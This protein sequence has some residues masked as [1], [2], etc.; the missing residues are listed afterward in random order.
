MTS[1]T[2]ALDRLK[3]SPQRVSV[4]LNAAIHQRLIHRADD[5]GRSLSNLIAFLL[6]TAM[7]RPS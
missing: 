6:E 1:A 4:T 7:G 5:E 3:R 2:A